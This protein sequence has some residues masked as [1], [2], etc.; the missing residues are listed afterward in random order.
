MS[1]DE[2]FRMFKVAIERERESY[3]L[4]KNIAESSESAEL[5]VVFER[6]AKEEQKHRDT[7]EKR[8]KIL[9]EYAF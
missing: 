2:L 1:K 7:I 8:Y 9:R 4:Y 3:E 6:L 5:K